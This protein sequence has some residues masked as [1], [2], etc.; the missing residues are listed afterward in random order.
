MVSSILNPSISF[1]PEGKICC[2]VP[3]LRINTD[4]IKL[5]NW[6]ENQR[7][8]QEL[9]HLRDAKICDFE[10]NPKGF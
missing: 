4:E 8:F 2:G 7:R 9:I 6:T 5:G 10:L 1:E 3:Q